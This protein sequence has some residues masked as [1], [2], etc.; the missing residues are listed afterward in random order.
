MANADG[1]LAD[2]GM[3]VDTVQ[4]VDTDAPNWSASLDFPM[5]AR[6][7]RGGSLEN[8]L[9]GFTAPPPPPPVQVRCSSRQPPARKTESRP[10]TRA[11]VGVVPAAAR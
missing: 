11:G 6:V 8:P 10:P 9:G 3:E 1:L 4:L 5:V 7:S 2:D